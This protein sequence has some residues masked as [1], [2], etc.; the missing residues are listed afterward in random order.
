MRLIAR[1]LLITLLH[2]SHLSAAQ[3]GNDFSEEEAI[4][5]VVMNYIEGTGNGE[6][7]K[8]RKAFHPDFNLYTV[9]NEDDLWI[10]SGEKYISIVE[11]GK[12]ANRI[13]RI[14]SVDYEENA[15]TA[16]AEIIVPGWRV[17]TDYFLLLKYQGNWKIVQKSY[18]SRAFHELDN[19]VVQ[20]ASIEELF[21]EFDSPDHPAVAALVIN[22]GEVIFKKAF[23][24][25]QLDSKIPATTST[26]F[27]LAGMSKHFT[28]FA[29]L[30]LAEQG[31]LSLTDD[32]RKY[33]SYL[34]QYDH[35]ITIN[36]LLTMTSG[37]P[38]FWSIKN[39]AGWHRDDVL[40]QEQVREMVSKMIPSFAPGDDY[41]YSNTDHWLLSEIIS[42]VSGQPFSDFMTE[43]IF[44]PLG[45]NKTLVIDDFEAY[46]PNL[47]ASYESDRN[48]GFKTFKY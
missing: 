29:T 36:H 43:E 33:V 3:K 6:P 2:V 9:N 31:Q 42:H 39:I 18:S 23:G 4:R 7:D 34:P 21:T 27:Q 47:A 41:I 40:T 32:I 15:A 37:L 13:G 20:D 38:D 44:K 28:A 17:F 22:K 19:P 8:L 45:M 24:S 26:K 5:A 46:I 35:V 16:K 14:I 10:R 1:I 12:K 48:G 25:V 11:P 30:L